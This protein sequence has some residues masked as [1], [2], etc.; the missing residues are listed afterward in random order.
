MGRFDYRPPVDFIKQLG[1][2]EEVDRY[3]PEMID[4][5]MPIVEKALK[6]NLEKHRGTGELIKSV[7]KSKAKK[8]KY[9]N[10][11][12]IVFPAGESTEYKTVKGETKARKT[13]VRNAEKLIYMEYGT[14]DQAAQPVIDSTINDAEPEVIDKMQEVFNREAGIK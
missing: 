8:N 2:L 10:Y 6:R 11:S 4:E 13:K 9:G 3:A 1:R 5:A 14:K 12:A 7:R